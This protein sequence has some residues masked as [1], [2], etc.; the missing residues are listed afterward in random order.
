MSPKEP[1]NS[2]RSNLYGPILNLKLPSL[3]DFLS[4]RPFSHY[5]YSVSYLEVT[6]F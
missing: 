2:Q 1:A 6:A 4:R 3:Y 5:L